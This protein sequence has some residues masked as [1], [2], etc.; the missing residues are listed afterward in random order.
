M[1]ANIT[2]LTNSALLAEGRSH[3]KSEIAN[4]GLFDDT[5]ALMVECK[6]RY[7]SLMRAARQF[8]DVYN[9][10]AERATNYAFA[11]PSFFSPFRAEVRSFE[12]ETKYALGNLIFKLHE[13][14]EGIKRADG[15]ALTNEFIETLPA[16]MKRVNLAVDVTGIN[17][18]GISDKDLA[19]VGLVRGEKRVWSWREVG[20]D[21][22]FGQ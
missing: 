21:D 14:R 8:R 22:D 12:R 1:N 2:T 10:L 15:E 6:S 5:L 16:E 18:E 11:T 9:L 19:K 7:D 4:R 3:V 17:R 20:G 13:G